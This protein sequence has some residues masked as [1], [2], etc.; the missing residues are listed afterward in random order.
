MK[1][2]V[3]DYDGTLTYKS[4]N[5]WVEMWRRLG[6]DLGENSVYYK[7]FSMYKN[8]EIDYKEW[9]FLTIERF[10]ERKMHATIINSIA[11]SIQLINGLDLAIKIFKQNGYDLHIVSGGFVNVITNT[12][13]VHDFQSINANQLYFDKDNHLSG[14]KITEYDDEG[15]AIFVEKLKD[16]GIK[17]KDIVFVGNGHNDEWVCKTG[18]KTIC[19]N[20][21]YKYENSYNKNIWNY[22]IKTSD[23]RSIL[24]LVLEDEKY[25]GFEQEK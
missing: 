17:T 18:C 8:N 15:K 9:C 3:F 10:K 22:R 2:V 5:P 11:N 25:K 21:S 24:P 12:V 16:K 4:S 13:N 19:L 1:A 6:F 7:Y 14:I 20:P 23:I